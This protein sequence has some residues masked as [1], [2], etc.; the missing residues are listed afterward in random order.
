MPKLENSPIPI[1]ADGDFRKFIL[2]SSILETHKIRE[3][4]KLLTDGLA[5]RYKAVAVGRGELGKGHLMRQFFVA[6]LNTRGELR[7]VTE[8]DYATLEQI[9]GAA[10]LIG[11][12]SGAIWKSPEEMEV[13]LSDEGKTLLRWRAT[14][15]S[16][17]VA[18]IRRVSGDLV[19]ISLLAAGRDVEAD[20]T[21]IAAL[22]QHLVRELRQTPFEPAFDLVGL[23]QR[24]LLATMTFSEGGEGNEQLVEA[25]ADRAFAAAYFRYLRLA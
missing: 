4:A 19:S 7:E 5:R 3:R 15:P 10:D 20:K 25:L 14:A 11:R 16:A 1:R 22:Q 13:V 9:P 18:T 17:G 21:T 12:C 8:Y 23:K 2:S 24:P 6:D